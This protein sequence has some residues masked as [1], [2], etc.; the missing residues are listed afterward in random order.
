MQLQLP[1]EQV[2]PH[3][4]SITFLSYIHAY[5]TYIM[6]DTAAAANLPSVKKMNLGATDFI[7]ATIQRKKAE[8]EVLSYIRMHSTYLHKFL[9]F[10]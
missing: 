3:I 6:L 7:E 2:I 10:W 4:Y 9:S 1:L 5:N 8:L